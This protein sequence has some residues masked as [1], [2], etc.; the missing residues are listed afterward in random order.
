MSVWFRD[1]QI[2]F[3]MLNNVTEHKQNQYATRGQYIHRKISQYRCSVFDAPMNSRTLFANH[4]FEIRVF[5]GSIF[6][7]TYFYI[8]H[9]SL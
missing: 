9:P 8:L 3:S 2:V 5:A 1:A 4:I 6:R 7:D